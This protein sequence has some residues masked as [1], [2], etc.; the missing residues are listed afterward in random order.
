MKVLELFAG[1]RSFS[2]VAEQ[3][4]HTTWDT[5]IEAFEGIDLAIDILD[6][7]PNMCPFIPDVIWCSP[8]CETFSVASIGRHW[9]SGFVFKPKSERAEHGVKVLERMI[10]LLRRYVALNPNVIWYVENPRGKMR[11]APQWD[12]L[13]HVR[14]TVTYCQYGHFAMKP[15]DIWTN[16]TE[17]VPRPM[18]KNGDPCHEPAPRH[19]KN[20]GTARNRNYLVRSQIPAPLC[21]E[22]VEASVSFHNHIIM[23]QNRFRNLTD[24]EVVA[25]YVRECENNGWTSTRATYLAELHT[26][27][28]RRFDCSEIITGNAMSLKTKEVE[29]VGNKIVLT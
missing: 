1:G 23:D 25:A 6:F 27:L 26:E 12:R 7:E 19:S 11:K 14:H 13:K 9:T 3:N 5:D 4:G 20:S 17:W 15:T 21:Q 16:N 28:F 18:C 10:S 24:P 2:K 29:L 22:I 8:P